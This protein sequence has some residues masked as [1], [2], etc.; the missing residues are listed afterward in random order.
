MT[1]LVAAPTAKKIKAVRAV[2]IAAAANHGL[3]LLSGCCSLGSLDLRE[4]SIPFSC[5]SYAIICDLRRRM[6]SIR[7]SSLISI[8]LGLLAVIGARAR[9][10]GAGRSPV[11]VEV[12]ARTCQLRQVNGDVSV[13]TG[14][15]HVTLRPR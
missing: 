15:E 4:A 12:E 10:D 8:T 5:L 3:D 1:A 7:R 11:I 2:A 9:R 13:S 6:S 14:N